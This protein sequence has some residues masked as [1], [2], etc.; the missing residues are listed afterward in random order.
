[1]TMLMHSCP[2]VMVKRV[3][4]IPAGD[5]YSIQSVPK[6]TCKWQPG[7][8]THQR[9]GC[10]QILIKANAILSEKCYKHIPDV[11][12][13]DEKGMVIQAFLTLQS[14]L[15]H[16][17]KLQTE[18]QGLPAGNGG[19]IQKGDAMGDIILKNQDLKHI[20]KIIPEKQARQP[21][22]CMHL[23]WDRVAYFRFGYKISWY[24][25]ASL[26]SNPKD[27]QHCH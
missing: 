24:I 12:G 2:L 10:W 4:Y 20:F 11:P 21:E 8:H 3:C 7:I 16:C 15:Q 14:H 25:K 26:S 27:F 19:N 1:M 6:Q 5:T 22:T 13:Y 23:I 17:M 18:K 9:A